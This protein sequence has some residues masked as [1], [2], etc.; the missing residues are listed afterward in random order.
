[1]KYAKL[2]I[3]EDQQVK[4][5]QSIGPE[6]N[7]LPFGNDTTN[8]IKLAPGESYSYLF[9]VIANNEQIQHFDVATNT[10]APKQDKPIEI[11]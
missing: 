1:M 4:L 6:P 11:D 5:L 8:L 10:N 7:H 9:K 3:I 2:S